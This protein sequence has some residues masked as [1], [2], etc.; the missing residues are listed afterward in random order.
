MDSRF[1]CHWGTP[2]FASGIGNKFGEPPGLP[3]DLLESVDLSEPT[4]RLGSVRSRGAFGM[5]YL[6]KRTLL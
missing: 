4:C 6:P 3:L 2:I 1:L 5:A